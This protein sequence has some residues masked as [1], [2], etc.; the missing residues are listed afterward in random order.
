MK[1]QIVEIY[2]YHANKQ[3]FFRKKSNIFPFVPILL[4]ALIENT[5]GADE[6]LQDTVS[7]PQTMSSG[8]NPQFV[9][10][11]KTN[12]AVKQGKKSRA[13]PVTKTTKQTTGSETTLKPMTVSAERGYEATDPYNPTYVQPDATTG[14]KTDTPIMETPLNVQVITKQVMKDQQVITLDQALKNVSGVTTTTATNGGFSQNIYLRG[15]PT[16]TIFR[17]GFRMDGG[18]SDYGNNQQFANVESIEVLKGPAAILYGR[19]EPG[20]M[21]NVITKK[22][23]ATPYYSL[24]QQFGSYNL[25]R[26]SI[27]ATGPVTK[28]DTLLYRMNAS[29]QNN[30]SFRD[31]VDGQNIFL[32]P[33]LKWNIN[34]RTQATLEMEY[35]HDN[36]SIDTQLLP[37]QDNHFINLPHSRNLQE[38]N[39]LATETIFAGLNW[40]HQFSDDW[41]IKHQMIMR[42]QDFN[43]G[44]GAFVFN[45]NNDNQQVDRF[46][47]AGHNSAD[48]Y[49]SI[50]DLTGHFKTWG[51]GHTLLFGGDYYRFNNRI[52][53]VNSG[54]VVPSSINYYDPIHPGTP[55]VL[56]PG[57]RVLLNT[58]TDNYGLYL[59]D[60]IKLPYNFHVMGG[61]RYQYI[62]STNASA[63]GIDS[64]YSSGV[65][66]TNDAVT[67]RVG[68]L[69]QPK[70]W[71]SLYSNYAENF[72]ANP[73]AFAFGGTDP[74]GNPLAPKPLGPTSAQQWE[75]GAKT[76]FFDGRLRATLA[77]FDLTKQNVA[78]TDASHPVE[79]GGAACSIALGGVESK[80]PEL[81]I[82]GEVLPGWK[83]IATYANQDVRITKSNDTADSGSTFLVG[84]RM[85]FVPRNIS[86]FWSTYEIQQGQLD[87]FKFGGGVNMQD[88][89]V[90]ADN[91]FKSPGYVL[92]GLMT[93]YSMQVGKS[94][95][96][97]QLNVNNL[98]DKSYFTN[99]A[100]QLG[101]GFGYGTFST[102][103]MLMGSI[104][105]QY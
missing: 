101:A 60:Q 39:P 29:Y 103:R 18:E 6:R 93:G 7:S 66:Q 37:F 22:P 73:N 4:C 15:F 31:L 74:S 1:K 54:F 99:A 96:T 9:G 27:D 97:A 80:G 92:V 61:L 68:L 20:G 63:F 50:L 13:Q 83:M 51:L 64:G 5:A 100:P 90:N 72:G 11:T 69:W 28:D 84:N 89:V 19:V 3:H 38:R 85:Q 86:S 88:S 81:D 14:T 46:L 2:R 71:L 91:T 24:N 35:Q 47:S 26:T 12:K 58:S 49:S 33:I 98:L 30:G 17:N 70:D 32:A 21:I 77:Y 105:I 55:A 102:P 65:P 23:L 57:T 87:G 59:Q 42:R 104:N 82:Q 45:I 95:I 67:P 16:P 41:S 76:E 36:S 25:Y 53:Q 78:T 75:V 8:K 94:K 52:N 34:P 43:Q 79:C 56:D 10:N 44:A 62:H 40:S 48:T